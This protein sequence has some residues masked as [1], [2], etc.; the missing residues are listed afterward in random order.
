MFSTWSCP[1]VLRKSFPTLFA[2]S[3]GYWARSFIV[4]IAATDDDYDN[5]MNKVNSR[6]I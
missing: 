6:R 2:Q 4:A 1:C 3:P 5:D